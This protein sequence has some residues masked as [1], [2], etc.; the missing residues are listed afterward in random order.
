MIK[1]IAF[2]IDGTLYRPLAFSLRCVP[3]VLR[4]LRFM[5]SFRQV[6]RDLHLL[7]TEGKVAEDFFLLQAELVAKSLNADVS[8][9][10]EFIDREIYLGWRKLFV[11]IKPYKDAV[12]TVLFAKNAGYKVGLL[13]DFPPEQKG[14][15]WGLAPSCDAILGSETFGVLKPH[16]KPFL[17]LAEML[18]VKPQELLYVGNSYKYDVLGGKKAGVKTALLCKWYEKFFFEGKSDIVFSSYKELQKKLKHFLE[19]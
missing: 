13:S 14:D 4:N 1:A 12:E 5:L 6:R 7:A 15:V 11:K 8:K 9:T 19:E 10:R 3:F 18:N 17:K 16:A 2:D